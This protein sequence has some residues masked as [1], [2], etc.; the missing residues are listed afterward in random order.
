VINIWVALSV[1]IVLILAATAAALWEQR[2]K[3]TP[4]EPKKRRR[5]IYTD[6][7]ALDPNVGNSDDKIGTIGLWD[8]YIK[9]L[10]LTPA[11]GAEGKDHGTQ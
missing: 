4:K 2:L 1:V 8:G 3:K 9:K 6:Q 5:N 11:G 10:T 7:I